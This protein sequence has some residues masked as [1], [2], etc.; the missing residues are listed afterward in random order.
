MDSKPDK[1]IDCTGLFCPMPIVHAREA[2]KEIQPGQVLCVHA[3]DPG[4]ENDLPAWCRVAG[5]E[6]I[7]M[8]KAGTIFKGTVRKK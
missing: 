8:E 3:D 6:F 2:I 7:S 5:H 4:F 1:T